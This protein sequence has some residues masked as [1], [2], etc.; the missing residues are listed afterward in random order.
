M[1]AFAER[2]WASRVFYGKQI[3]VEIA[4]DPP[5]ILPA[6]P[7]CLFVYAIFVFITFLPSH[8]NFG[9]W[10]LTSYLLLYINKALV[11]SNTDYTKIISPFQMPKNHGE[12]RIKCVSNASPTIC[13][14]HQ[15]FEVVKHP[16]PFLWSC[17]VHCRMYSYD[18]P[19]TAGWRNW[20]IPL[21]ILLVSYE[22]CSLNRTMLWFV[23][24]SV[25]WLEPPP[26]NEFL[27][28]HCCSECPHNKIF[29]V[30]P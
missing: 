8:W 19:E 4:R 1:C 13:V 7:L 16:V 6:S 17:R 21:H 22:H 2:Q 27:P 25:V 26:Y 18:W 20:L 28:Q 14:W 10:G 23:M 5:Y 30:G 29:R 15:V 3:S 9:G 24:M 12:L 11:N